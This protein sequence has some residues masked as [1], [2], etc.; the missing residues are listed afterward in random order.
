M[1]IEIVPLASRPGY[2]KGGDGDWYPEQREL[3]ERRQRPNP[4][5]SRFVGRRNVRRR[6]DREALVYIAEV[7]DAI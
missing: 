7:A 1:D 3:A 4:S 2:F 5:F 6:A